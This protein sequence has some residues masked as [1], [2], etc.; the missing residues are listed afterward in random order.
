M[1]L[2]ERFALSEVAS[3]GFGF[4]A[5][6]DQQDEATF[7]GTF[8]ARAPRVRYIEGAIHF[9]YGVQSRGRARIRAT[10][11]ASKRL[12]LKKSRTVLLRSKY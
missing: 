9:P 4:K 10:I 11:P 6:L 2:A 12:C 3:L 8:V 5:K 1:A 7:E